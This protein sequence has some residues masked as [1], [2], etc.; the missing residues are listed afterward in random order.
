[1]MGAE[2][3]LLACP[4]RPPRRAELIISL[5]VLAIGIFASVVAFPPARGGGYARIGPNFMPHVVAGVLILLGLWLLGEV[6]TGGW[7]DARRM[8]PIERGEH[9]FASE[10]LPLGERRA[11]RCRWR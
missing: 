2:P 8:T 11:A 1:M 4:R 7:S 9:A 6:F 3:R 10:R 5:G